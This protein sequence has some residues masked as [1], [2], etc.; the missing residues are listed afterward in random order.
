MGLGQTI[1]KVEIEVAQENCCDSA[2][3]KPSKRL[4]QSLKQLNQ[5]VNAKKDATDRFMQRYRQRPSTPPSAEQT[6]QSIRNMFNSLDAQR[7]WR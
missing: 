6:Q 2:S 1:Q 7:G 4:P 3:A 5:S